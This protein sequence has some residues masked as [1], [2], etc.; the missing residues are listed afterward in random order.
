MEIKFCLYVLGTKTIHVPSENYYS[1][2]GDSQ[3]YDLSVW[4]LYDEYDSEEEAL[5]ELRYS[6]LSLKG[7]TFQI[8]KTIKV[9]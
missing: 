9:L 6:A 1:K 8:I 3:Q 5:H 2:G 4:E 7:K